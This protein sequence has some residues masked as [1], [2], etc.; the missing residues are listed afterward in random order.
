MARNDNQ[1]DCLFQLAKDTHHAAVRVISERNNSSFLGE[2]DNQT[3]VLW[4]VRSSLTGYT[5][6]VIHNFPFIRLDRYE[7]RGKLHHMIWGFDILMVS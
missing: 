2:I 4:R 5:I 7:I 1:R 6:M 3:V